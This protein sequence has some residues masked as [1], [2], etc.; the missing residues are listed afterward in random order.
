MNQT[1]CTPLLNRFL[2][3]SGLYATGNKSL[4]KSAKK[5]VEEIN[6]SVIEDN[7]DYLIER[8]MK[9]R[10]IPMLNEFLIGEYLI[11]H[12]IIRSLTDVIK[13]TNSVINSKYFPFIHGLSKTVDVT[14]IKGVSLGPRYYPDS[15]PRQMA[16]IDLLVAPSDLGK[17][18]SYF[19]EHNFFQG[20]FNRNTMTNRVLD[21][22]EYQ[23]FVENH[24]ELP[25]FLQLV[26]VPELIKHYDLIDK[27]FFPRDYLLTVNGKVQLLMEIDV[28]FNLSFDIALSDVFGD[29]LMMLHGNDYHILSPEVYVWFL[30]ARLYVE[31][32]VHK[33]SPI[34]YLIDLS[35]IIANEKQLDWERIL[36]TGT[37]YRME[38]SFYYVF[39]HLAGWLDGMIPQEILDYL[40][41]NATKNLYSKDNHGDFWQYIVESPLLYPH[42][43]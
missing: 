13:T 14:L 34:R 33:G 2:I 32:M 29:N 31:S 41:R 37:K 5:M 17:V 11:D 10:L 3:A 1:S 19:A 4:V 22:D 36:M 27:Y 43:N 9:I 25:P 28:H 35:A 30:T 24:Y 16:D 6:V 26:E 23:R 18:T 38:F 21:K 20:E 7:I 42:Q 15:L 39:T 40:E 8:A 12:P